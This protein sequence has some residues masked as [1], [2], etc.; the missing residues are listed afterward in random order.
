MSLK[1]LHYSFGHKGDYALPPIQPLEATELP[2]GYSNSQVGGDN[3]TI[4]LLLY[5]TSFLSFSINDLDSFLRKMFSQHPTHHNTLRMENLTAIKVMLLNA[6]KYLYL[7]N[8]FIILLR[9]RINT[10]TT[11]ICVTRPRWGGFT[12]LFLQ[13]LQY[14]NPKSV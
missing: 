12:I 6:S 2:N 7:M 13:Y 8:E 9:F 11:W 3:S 1:W 10:I 4:I 14:C 5:I